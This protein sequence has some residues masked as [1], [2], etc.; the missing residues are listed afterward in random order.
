MPPELRAKSAAEITL[1]VPLPRIHHARLSCDAEP[2]RP[3]SCWQ[4]WHDGEVKLCVAAVLAVGCRPSV[5]TG[6]P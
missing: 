2:L 1:A 3:R 6:A 5:C 4:A